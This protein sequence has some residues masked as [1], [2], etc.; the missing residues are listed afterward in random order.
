[1]RLIYKNQKISYYICERRSIDMKLKK[2]LTISASALLLLSVAPAVNVNAQNRTHSYSPTKVVR[3][4]PMSRR[5]LERKI[6]RDENNLASASESD[7]ISLSKMQHQ[8]DKDESKL[9]RMPIPKGSKGHSHFYSQESEYSTYKKNGKAHHHSSIITDNN[10]H[11]KRSKHVNSRKMQSH[12]QKLER[13]IDRSMAKIDK[14]FKD[15][16]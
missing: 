2:L 3:L 10:G 15:S 6:N 5:A 9:D 14:I 4:H 11:I 1:M 13:K 7:E 16:F 12:F 8:L